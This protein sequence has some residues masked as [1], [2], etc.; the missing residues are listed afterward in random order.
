LS[1]INMPGM[2]GL[3]L[4]PK[5]KV[6]RPDVPIIMITA[7]GDAETT[8]LALE[9]RGNLWPARRLRPTAV[10]YSEISLRRSVGRPWPASIAGGAGARLDHSISEHSATA[11]DRPANQSRV[12]WASYDGLESIRLAR[13]C[14]DTI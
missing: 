12:E 6:I 1:D 4:L 14:H 5:V 2:S 8:R 3:E 11:V 13:R 7:Y 10:D 9:N